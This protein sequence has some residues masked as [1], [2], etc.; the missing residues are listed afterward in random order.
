MIDDHSG[1]LKRMSESRS[2]PTESQGAEAVG[3]LKLIHDVVFGHKDSDSVA[4]RMVQALIAEYAGRC[5]P[6]NDE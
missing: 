3:T 2:R 1:A 6:G 4:R 5:F